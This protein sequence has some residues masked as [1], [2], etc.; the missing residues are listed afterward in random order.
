MILREKREELFLIRIQRNF[1]L[2]LRVIKLLI[3]LIIL[4]II[5]S[6]K[7]AHIPAWGYIGYPSKVSMFASRIQIFHAKFRSIAK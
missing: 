1:T 4:Q 7:F 5:L 2:Q 6:T 3:E